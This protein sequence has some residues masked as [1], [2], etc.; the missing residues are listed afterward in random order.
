[1]MKPNEIEFCKKLEALKKLVDQTFYKLEQSQFLNSENLPERKAAFQLAC[2]N[3][4]DH[5]NSF[6]L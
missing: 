5:A 3:F 2:K 1:M 4:D 6:K